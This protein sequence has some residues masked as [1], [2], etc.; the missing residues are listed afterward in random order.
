MKQNAPKRILAALALLGLP[1]SA[2]AEEPTNTKPTT[3][4]TI[5]KPATDAKAPEQPKPAE[6]KPTPAL[7]ETKPAQPA[8]TTPPPIAKGVKTHVARKG[9]TV[10]GIAL[11]NGITTDQLAIWNHM[12]NADRLAIGQRLE[13]PA[14]TVK[15]RTAK[16]PP[17]A[18]GPKVH[19]VRK[20]ESLGVIAKRYGV[21]IENLAKWNHLARPDSLKIGACLE[22]PPANAAPSTVKKALVPASPATAAVKSLEPEEIRITLG[23]K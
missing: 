12:A 22:I 23:S 4:V 20:G 21:S 5:A 2:L 15:Q 19:V 13:I 18:E 8:P 16:L 1:F 3:S 7:T 17:I 14:K 6:V 10:S 9:E 11:R